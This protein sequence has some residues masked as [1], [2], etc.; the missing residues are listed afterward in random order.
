M[1]SG[2]GLSLLSFSTIFGLHN[3]AAAVRTKTPLGSSIKYCQDLGLNVKNNF[4]E[5]ASK[6]LMNGARILC[7]TNMIKYGI[8]KSRLPYNNE[9][10]CMLNDV[11]INE[12]NGSERQGRVIESDIKN[13]IS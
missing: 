10:M 8:T 4:V 3:C 6:A 2:H 5:K 13:F 9:I 7:D 1:P 12:I 11:N